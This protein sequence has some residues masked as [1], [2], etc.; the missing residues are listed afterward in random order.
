MGYVRGQTL[1]ERLRTGRVAWLD[2]LRML[3][4]LADAVASAHRQGIIHRDI[5]PANIL[6]DERTGRAMLADFGV[7]TVARADDE[8]RGA[9]V[10]TP[11]YMAPEQRHGHAVDER[12]DVYALGL[13]AFEM[14]AGRPTRDAEHDVAAILDAAP[15]APPSFVAIV[16]R[17]LAQHPDDRWRGG[18]DLKDALERAAADA[19]QPLPE[20]VRDLPSFG[21]YAVLW[22]AAWS[23]FA[24]MQGHEPSERALLLLIA[25]LVPLGLGIHV[26]NVGR[27]G[28]RV[29][30]LARVAAWPPEW[31]GMWW[32]KALR[33]PTDLWP[34]L[35]LIA[36]VV[37]VSLSAVF[38]LV[39]G[40]IVLRQW[41]QRRGGDGV[42]WQWFLVAQA[43][44]VVLA[45]A[46]VIVA[47]EWTRRRGLSGGETARL[48]FGATTESSSWRSP[49]L[50]RLLV[51]APD[52][53]TEK[54]R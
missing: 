26:W 13:V 21:A 46:V 20:S 24:L 16:M 6:L 28:L 42:D 35:P 33:R 7:A 11:D 52:A 17:C 15:D 2:A 4:E 5:K 27:P 19:A 30:E 10:G 22:A 32:P 50:A 36:R 31:W 49:S 39:P 45:G 38:L 34:R 40:L 51:P 47:L 53:S 1:A 29:S 54:G 37:R 8:P 12:S 23:V 18:S 9:I 3:V 25:F 41:L 48:L 14:L 43:T 44:V